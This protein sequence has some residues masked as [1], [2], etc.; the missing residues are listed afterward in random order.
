MKKIFIWVIIIVAVLL[1]GGFKMFDKTAVNN[2]TAANVN[3]EMAGYF[4]E[5]M[6]TVGVAD[7]GMPIEGFDAGLLIMAYPGL[8]PADFQGVETVEGKYEVTGDEIVFLR[9]AS[10]P[11]TSAEEMVSAEGY[12]TLLAKV[13]TRLKLPAT[14]EAEVDL[15]VETLDKEN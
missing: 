15:I 14:T 1:I 5:R 13:S 12:R 4:Q 9:D 10:K 3:E 8:V 7:I 6:F 2:S 11:I